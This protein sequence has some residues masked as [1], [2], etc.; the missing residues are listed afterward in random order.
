[1]D[2]VTG[3]DGTFS[4]LRIR[5]FRYLWLGQISH[6]GALWME[7]IARPFLILD[8]TDGSGVHLGG[9]A[10]VRTLPQ[11]L[12]GLVAGVISDWFD[13]R[14]ILVLVKACVLAINIAFAG[15]LV[16]GYLELSH[17]Y[18]YAF[19]R[20]SMMAFDQPARQAMIPST[21]PIHR[22]TNAIALMSATQNTMRI[23]G[24]TLGGIAYAWL[25]AEGTFLSIAVIYV[26]AVVY[27]YLLDV[28]THER[29]ESSELADMGRG[30]V[31]GM[32]FAFHHVA[33]RGVLVL[34]LVYFTFGMSYMQVFL[35]LF[36]DG[37]LEIGSAGFGAMSSISGA[38]ALVAA[39]FIARRQPTR[40]GAV[41]PWTVTAF[42][43][44]LVLFSLSTYLPR[45]PGLVGLLLP[46]ALIAVIGGLQTGFFSLSRSLMLHASPEHL[47]GRVLSLLSL[48]RALMSAGAALA[49]FLAAAQGVQLAQ[50]TY[51]LICFAGGF[52]VYALAR[53]FRRSITS[54]ELA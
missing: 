45:P 43:A 2:A 52:A 35:P 30:I 9:V 33:I 13:R 5:N 20:G 23:A 51:G 25:G 49:G 7:Q 15:I 32:R 54:I 39:I 1:M 50:I 21:V 24:A 44:V 53:D 4:S 17:I 27:T 14:T 42:G 26:P 10:A 47:R 6:A 46:F 31:E 22:L 3:R 11:L 16:A 28:P 8:I 37:V 29:P 48:D 12:F 19:L 18:V 41:L 38:G 36:A 40:L 34:S